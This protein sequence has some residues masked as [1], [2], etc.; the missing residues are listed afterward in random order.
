MIPRYTREKMGKIWEPENRFSIWLKIEILA[1]EAHAELGEIPG[2]ALNTIKA[3]AGFSIPRIDEIEDVVKHDVIAFLT[4]VGERVGPDARYIHLG[5]TSSDVLDTCFAVQL[6]EAGHILLD[7]LDR[8]M[9]VLRKQA[10]KHKYTVMIGRT[11]G[12]HAEPI[13]FGLKMA[14]WYEE[15][16]RNRKRMEEALENISY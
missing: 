16:R 2:P 7:D 3:K 11:H 8:L 9:E 4:C 6:K 12:M 5:M 13:T 10:L 1:C 15:V 14:L